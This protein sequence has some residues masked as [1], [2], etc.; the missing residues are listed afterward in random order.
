MQSASPL[1]TTTPLTQLAASPRWFPHALDPLSDQLLLVERPEADYR[2]A[3]FLD[4]RSLT[5]GTPRRI[6]AWAELERALPGNA[7]QD[8]DYIFH[9]GHVG[10]TLVSRLLG[11]LG[12]VF[13]LREPLLLRTLHDLAAISGAPDSPWA[14]EWL[15]PRL[16]TARVLL[17][18]TFRPAQRAMVKATS[19][20]SDLAPLLV[21]EGSRALLMF[22]A[23]ARYLEN[24]LAGEASRRELQMVSGQRLKRLAG[25]LGEAPARLWELDEGQKAALGWACE[26]SA[27]IAAADAL[28]AHARWC[29]FSDFLLTPGDKL[30]EIA[31]F[32]DHS[33]TPA[34]ATAIAA[35]P[36]MSRY[37]KGLDHAY[38][39]KLR[40][41]VLA[42]SRTENRTAI[43]GGLAWLEQAAGRHPLLARCLET[44][45]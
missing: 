8:A 22:D 1:P 41:E 44:G 34:E 9:I 25:R 16:A 13:A 7:R 3:S 45:S 31:D 35:G 26:M 42:R 32:F 29:D 21:P 11:E 24:I 40:G 36:Y 10:S 4:D 20:T 17:S 6:V 33:I 23:P 18:R 28:G 27:L 14:P 2:A 19:F 37:S 43:A 15:K 30:N 38:S 39:P 12:T 5:Q